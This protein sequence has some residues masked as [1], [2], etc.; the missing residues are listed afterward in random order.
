MRASV[1]CNHLNSLHLT[2]PQ[3]GSIS[4]MGTGVLN[5]LSREDGGSGAVSSR[6]AQQA[7]QGR[8]MNVSTLNQPL[9]ACASFS[10]SRSNTPS[11]VKVPL[12][13]P[14]SC[15][16]RCYHCADSVLPIAVPARAVLDVNF[17]DIIGSC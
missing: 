9:C 10:V 12:D 7:W 8:R 13:E 16:H 6:F 2:V 15:L 11:S 4:K 1:G 5:T 3:F 17:R 14:S